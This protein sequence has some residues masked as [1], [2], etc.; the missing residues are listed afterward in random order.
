VVGFY[1]R[2]EGFVNVAEGRV[3]EAQ[4]RKA[5]ALAYY[6]RVLILPRAQAL[7]KD[8]GG[9]DDGWLAWSKPVESSPAESKPIAR[10]AAPPSVPAEGAPGWMK[11]DRSFADLNL[12]DLTGKT[13]TVADLQ[14]KMTLIDVWASW[15]GPCTAELPHIQELYDK[16]KTRTDVQLVTLNVDEN[17]GMADLLV[18]KQHYTFPV[19]MAEGYFAQI[20]P[21]L[22]VPRTWIADKT[23]AAHLEKIN[24]NEAT[25][26]PTFVQDVLD[27][28]KRQ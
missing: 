5:D 27:Q 14:G 6:Q 9:T 19:L 18:K 21:A 15:C 10:A 25:G 12:P 1:P 11:V 28:L 17:P 24:S 2:C 16:I 4:G 7:W 22:S 26:S 13:W 20:Q 8:L 23:G 3:A